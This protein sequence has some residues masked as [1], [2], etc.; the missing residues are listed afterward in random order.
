MKI[1][2]G[3]EVEFLFDNINLA[4]EAADEPNSHGYI[5]YKIKPKTTVQL[6]DVF[7][8]DA[9]IYFDYNLPI[10]T[11]TV[12]T[13]VVNNLST[14]EFSVSQLISIY[15]YP[16]KDGLLL[17]TKNGVSITSAKIYDL[18]GTKL[19]DIN[20]SV[21]YINT[22]TLS[23]GIYLLSVQTNQGKISKKIIKN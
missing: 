7:S 6:G 2:N 13:T 17:N 3:N 4:Y 23:S 21:E 18:K 12:S 14:D 11:N 9:S 8:G 22:E 5:A 19:I 15:P 10:I 16:V 1:T 20:N